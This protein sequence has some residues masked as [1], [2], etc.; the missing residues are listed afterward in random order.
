M[1]NVYVFSIDVSAG[2]LKNFLEATKDLSADA[3]AE[4]LEADIGLSSA[5]EESAQGG[6]TEAPSRDEKVDLHFIALVEKDGTLY[7]LG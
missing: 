2:H 3:R 7:E 6:Q 5:H 1:N 4:K